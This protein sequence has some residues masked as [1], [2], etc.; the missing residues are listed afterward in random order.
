[1]DRVW[2][3]AGLLDILGD[4]SARPGPLYR[5]LAA[6]IGAAVD[7]GELAGRD[8]LPSERDLARSLAVSRA[9]VVAAYDELSD[10][11][12]LLRRQGSGTTVRPGTA[13]AR[14]GR[15]RGGTAT[16]IVQ[17][18]VDGPSEI[19]SLARAAEP[20]LPAVAAAMRDV[21][22]ADL[23]HLLDDA[24]Y[25]PRGLPA[26]RQLLADRY[27]K[28]GVTTSA[29]QIVVTTGA[30]QAIS[31]VGQLLLSRGTSVVVEAPGWPGS[32][33]SFLAAGAR[34]LPVPLDDEGIRLDILAETLA[35]QRPQL[36]YVMPTY[37][38]PTGILMAA[39]RRRQVADIAGRHG[40]PILEDSTDLRTDP[41][42][43]AAHGTDVF[44]VGTLSK[45]VWGGLRVGWIR[46][47]LG[48]AARI[49]R[50]KALADLGSPVLDQA[51][52]ARL[53]PQ[54][55][56][57]VARQAALADERRQRLSA[58]L[59][60]RLPEWRW[61]APTGGTGLW[62]ELPGVDARAF[63][64]VALR[65]G[66]EVVPG[67]S[68]DITGAHDRFV[69]VPYTF[70]TDVLDALVDRLVAAWAEVHGMPGGA[71]RESTS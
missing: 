57:L 64:Q 43:I 69:R 34:V 33:D 16:P 40:V 19:I 56:R 32:M 36:L 71:G 30:T 6:A 1:M 10:S 14:T 26:L 62:V 27:T 31:L 24:G 8:R 13:R 66:V 25:H 4:W 42:P 12:T 46:T 22:A 15:V 50:L 17:R 18:L 59:T 20:G 61:R 54:L 5:R 38:N 9:T 55:D 44:T 28:A 53:L 23:P 7:T 60:A 68:A 52:A 48:N 21:V 41:A 39:P 47:S 65:H 51:V 63:A 35:T 70:T 3:A 49:A 37:H 67:S 29:D 58:A 45:A 2:D 11:R